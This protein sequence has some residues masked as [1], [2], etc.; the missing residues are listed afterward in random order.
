MDLKLTISHFLD[1]LYSYFLHKA[2]G[3]EILQ[4]PAQLL[5][6]VESWQFSS[7][8]WARTQP[9]SFYKPVY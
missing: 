4:N 8:K 3:S 2:K 6:Y 1:S 5:G 9:F 7:A